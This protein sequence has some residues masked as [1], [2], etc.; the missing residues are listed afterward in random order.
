MSRTKAQVLLDELQRWVEALTLADKPAPIERVSG[1]VDGG[2]ALLVQNLSNEHHSTGIEVQVGAGDAEVR[3]FA[4]SATADQQAG[5]GVIGRGDYG[6]IGQSPD[7]VGVM[8]FGTTG[9]YGFSNDPDGRGVE[10]HTASPSGTG[11]LASAP[12][13]EITALAIDTGN[14]RV[15]G[16]GQNTPTPVF[17]HVASE[18]NTRGAVTIIDNPMTNGDPNAILL[19]TRRLLAITDLADRIAETAGTSIENFSVGYNT[20]A[21]KW[22]IVQHSGKPIVVN[23]A[24]NVLA[25]KV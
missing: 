3:N 5:I 20:Q 18:R 9:L 15:L 4:I 2:P 1:A 21:A 8:G 17:I 6:V 12:E 22:V 25:F 10:G 14:I 19:V 7:N 16:A 24:F 11:V 13:P 23:T